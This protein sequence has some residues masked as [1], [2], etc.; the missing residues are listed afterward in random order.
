MILV[1]S[2]YLDGKIKTIEGYTTDQNEANRKAKELNE[3]TPNPIID[4]YY[5]TTEVIDKIK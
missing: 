1:V 3:T 4:T 2:K 5:Y